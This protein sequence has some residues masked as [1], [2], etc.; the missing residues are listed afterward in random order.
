MTMQ[1]GL[2]IGRLIMTHDS[3]EVAMLPIG[4]QRCVAPEGNVFYYHAER[5]RDTYCVT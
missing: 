1:I 4:W 3:Y 2:N 5:V